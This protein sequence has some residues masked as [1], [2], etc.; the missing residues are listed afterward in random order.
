MIEQTNISIGN[1]ESKVIDYTMLLDN[2][3]WYKHEYNSS[4]K[5][6]Y[7]EDYNYEWHEK[8]MTIEVI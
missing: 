1:K 8:N 6:T 5:E 2:G 3:F 7:Y 4:G